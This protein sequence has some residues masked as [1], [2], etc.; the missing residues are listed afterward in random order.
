M[1]EQHTERHA[2]SARKLYGVAEKR[3]GATHSVPRHIQIGKRADGSELQGAQRLVDGEHDDDDVLWGLRRNSGQYHDQD[4]CPFMNSKSNW[5]R[6][7]VGGVSHEGMFWYIP[8]KEETFES[9][10]SVSTRSFGQIN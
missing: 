3:V 4:R 5:A 6:Q 9:R 10:S 2:H 7:G 1:Q 8:W